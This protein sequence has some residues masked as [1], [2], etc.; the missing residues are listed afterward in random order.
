MRARRAALAL[1]MIVLFVPALLAI[2]PAFAKEYPRDP[3]EAAALK[4]KGVRWTDPEIR[5]Y[6]LKLS[7]SI[8][9]SNEQWTREGLSSEQRARRAYEIRHNARR[10][11]R[12]MMPSTLERFALKV[13]DF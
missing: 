5:E 12:A 13:R 2:A 1:T 4:A 7:G 6:Y 9:P 8:A 11:C 10:T 3:A